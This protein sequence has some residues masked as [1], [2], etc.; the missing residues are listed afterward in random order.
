M[1]I[2]IIGAGGVGG[3]YGAKLAQ[4]GHDVTLLARGEHLEATRKNGMAAGDSEL[5]ALSRAQ[6][7]MLR[8][9]ATAGPFYWAGF[10]D[11]DDGAGK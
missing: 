5:T 1:R 8:N 3:Y 6:R 4:A 10:V 7:E 9:S 2:A 11:I